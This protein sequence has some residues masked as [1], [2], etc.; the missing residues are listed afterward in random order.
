M[1][2]VNASDIAVE[3]DKVN[4]VFGEPSLKKPCR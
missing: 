4:I 2:A 3:F 1:M